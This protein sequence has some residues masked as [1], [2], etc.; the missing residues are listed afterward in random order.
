[1]YT[2]FTIRQKTMRWRERKF[3]PSLSLNLNWWGKINFHGNFSFGCEKKF[4]SDF[5]LVSPAD[6]LNVMISM[7]REG[8]NLIL[9]L[10]CLW[11]HSNNIFRAFQHFYGTEFFTLNIQFHRV[12]TMTHGARKRINKSSYPYVDVTSEAFEEMKGRNPLELDSRNKRQFRGIVGDDF[13]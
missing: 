12:W 6:D 11:F 2:Y 10:L 5:F 4:S 3:L 7:W 8:R 9:Y 13:F 1:M